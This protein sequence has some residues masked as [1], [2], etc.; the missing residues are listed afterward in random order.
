MQKSVSIQP[1]T[2]LSKFGSDFI[3]LFIH[4]LRAAWRERAGLDNAAALIEHHAAPLLVPAVG[5]AVVPLDAQ[6]LVHP[7]AAWVAK[8]KDWIEKMKFNNEFF[9]N[10]RNFWH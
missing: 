2:S 8:P 6:A 9:I 10:P 5:C 4:V 7:Q 1:R 3:H